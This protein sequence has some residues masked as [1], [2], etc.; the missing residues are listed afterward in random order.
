MDGKKVAGN[1]EYHGTIHHFSWISKSYTPIRLLYSRITRMS[2]DSMAL[3][4]R[5]SAHSP[6]VWRRNFEISKSLFT[7]CLLLDP[8]WRTWRRVK[9]FEKWYKIRIMKNV[10][11]LPR[12]FLLYHNRKKKDGKWWKLFD[13]KIWILTWKWNLI[14]VESDFVYH[15]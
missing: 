3:S 11:Y 14:F 8:P 4:P 9:L 2:T 6:G 15:C 13:T 10:M 12:F 1:E 7:V 5:S